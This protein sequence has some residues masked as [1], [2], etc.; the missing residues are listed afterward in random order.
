MPDLGLFFWSSIRARPS[1]IVNSM[2]Q[3]REKNIMRLLF[4]VL[5]PSPSMLARTGTSTDTH[6]E[7]WPRE[8]KRG[9]TLFNGVTREGDF[10]TNRAIA[11]QRGSLSIGTE[12]LEKSAA[13]GARGR[14][15][16]SGGHDGF[17]LGCSLSYYQCR[18]QQKTFS[19]LPE[20]LER[21]GPCQLLQLRQTGT[22]GV[23]L[24][25]GPFLGWFV[26]LVV[27]VQEILSC[28]GCFSRPSTFHFT[29]PHRP[30]S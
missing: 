1:R 3:D 20:R 16:L 8:M 23:H 19:L 6:R 5:A 29:C 14:K 11:K 25:G 7:E 30:A 22:Q 27:P 21:G 15:L 2:E 24:K 9:T 13:W 26:G 10:E 4:Y 18:R 28:L 12:W 17:L